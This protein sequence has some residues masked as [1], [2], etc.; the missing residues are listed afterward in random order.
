MGARRANW[1]TSVLSCR[2]VALTEF[3]C[4]AP[5]NVTEFPQSG[6]LSA[7]GSPTH[8]EQSERSCC[9]YLE[10]QRLPG[11]AGSLG[12]RHGLPPWDQNRRYLRRQRRCQ[13]DSATRQ[14][15]PK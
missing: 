8:H 15:H 7:E 10:R 13:S 11:R 4:T 14:D 9:S 5:A 12:G 6:L 3:L 1:I 2:D